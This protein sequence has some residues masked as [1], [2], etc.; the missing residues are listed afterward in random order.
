MRYALWRQTRAA[1]SSLTLKER[2]KRK[3]ESLPH[4]GLASKRNTATSKLWS[5]GRNRKVVCLG[6]FG[7]LCFLFQGLL[8][9]Y[10][11]R[12]GKFFSLVLVSWSV[13]VLRLCFD[14]SFSFERGLDIPWIHQY[15]HT[16]F[17][18]SLWLVVGGLKGRNRV[19]IQ[20]YYVIEKV[21]NH[22]VAG[23]TMPHGIAAK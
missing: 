2:K 22:L 5:A 21:W 10:I 20:L 7:L 15:I 18:L 9:H 17:S 6:I 8:T 13:G 4:Q 3:V 19:I 14:L 11:P 12:G 1:A 23:G 16:N